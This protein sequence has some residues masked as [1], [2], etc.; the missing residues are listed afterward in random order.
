M[1]SSSCIFRV[2][3][4]RTFRELMSG[5]RSV[6]EE[7]KTSMLD[8]GDTDM[9]ENTSLDWRR[10]QLGQK[11]DGAK[12]GGMDPSPHVEEAQVMD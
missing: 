1:V 10:W 7:D 11:S 12:D 2:L 9:R 4:G 6:V 3:A 8:E 5:S